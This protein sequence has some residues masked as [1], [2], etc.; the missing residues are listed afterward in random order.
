MKSM[1][2]EDPTSRPTADEILKHPFIY[3]K[4]KNSK[5]ICVETT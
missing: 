3:N 2:S 4:Q 1:L 5:F